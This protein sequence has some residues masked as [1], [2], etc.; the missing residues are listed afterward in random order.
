M[1]LV[2]PNL[3]VVCNQPTKP[4]RSSFLAENKGVLLILP[5]V[6]NRHICN[7]TPEMRKGLP[8]HTNWVVGQFATDPVPTGV[9]VPR[10][11]LLFDRMGAIFVPALRNSRGGSSGIAIAP[12]R[13]S[14]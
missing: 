14:G 13:D 9:P 8:A 1:R 7:Y 5:Q 12:L 3:G 10:Q 11:P 6:P 4:P 2:D